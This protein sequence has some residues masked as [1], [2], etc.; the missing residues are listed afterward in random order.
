MES[1][2]EQ[3]IFS[4]PGVDAEA[5]VALRGLRRALDRTPLVPAEAMRVL[6]GVAS[7][8]ELLGVSEVLPPGHQ[9]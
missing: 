2:V 5:Q 4:T 3:A 8:G 1:Y 9:R 6:P 7:A